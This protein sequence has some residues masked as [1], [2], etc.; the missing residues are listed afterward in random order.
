ML[1]FSV[2]GWGRHDQWAVGHQLHRTSTYC[3]AAASY[4]F[5][6][7][8][9]YI[10]I[11]ALLFRFT[12]SAFTRDCS[13]PPLPCMLDVYSISIYILA[14]MHEVNIVTVVRSVHIC[15]GTYK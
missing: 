13:F 1:R 10:R 7:L 11:I 9:L 14:S 5:T 6:P 2:I 3:S 4:L 15:V 8:S 12:S